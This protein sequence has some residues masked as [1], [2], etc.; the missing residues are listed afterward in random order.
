MQKES[1]TA[2]KNFSVD[3]YGEVRQQQFKADQFGSPKGASLL[4]IE[5]FPT[6]S[7][8]PAIAV[9]PFKK[10]PLRAKEV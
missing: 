6:K 1:V 4:N 3:L 2:D 5:R 10:P 7:S 8:E 9:N